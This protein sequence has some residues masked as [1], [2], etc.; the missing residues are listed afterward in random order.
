MT[1]EGSITGEA[2]DPDSDSES[3]EPDQNLLADLIDSD[4]DPVTLND[5]GAAEDVLAGI[6]AEEL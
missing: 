6:Q 5:M 3:V 2:I 4:S 1:H